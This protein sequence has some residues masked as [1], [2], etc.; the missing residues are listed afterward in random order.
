[1]VYLTVVFWPL[2]DECSSRH[3]RLLLGE[4][5]SKDIF[6]ALPELEVFVSLQDEGLEECL[7]LLATRFPNGCDGQAPFGR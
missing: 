2:R 6:H 7:R 5:S 4:E 1:M 3:H